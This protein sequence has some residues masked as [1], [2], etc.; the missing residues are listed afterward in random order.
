MGIFL[1]GNMKLYFENYIVVGGVND[2]LFYYIVQYG[3]VKFYLELVYWFIYFMYNLVFDQLFNEF[4]FIIC[5]NVLIYFNCEL[6]ECVFW[7]FDDS[8]V[9]LG[10]FCFGLKEILKFLVVNFKYIMV[11]K[12]KI[13]K[14]IKE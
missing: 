4:Y 7:F 3:G 10:Y 9:V 6:Q 14:K 1:L 5:W 13:W 11:S 8:F 12:E 2:F